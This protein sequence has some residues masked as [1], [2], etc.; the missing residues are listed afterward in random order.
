[1]KD[2]L[3]ITNLCKSYKKTD[4]SLKNVTITIPCG[5]I[6]GF[7]GKNGAGKSTTINALLGIG[8]KDSGTV[9]L[10]GHDLDDNN[11]D[12]RNEIGVVF[13]NTHF[14][15]ENTPIMIEKVMK[16]IYNNWDSNQFYAF[17]ERFSL[18]INKKVKTFSRGMMMKLSAAVALSHNA[19]F[20]IL[21]EATA[22]LDPV[23][24]EELLDILLEFVE[25]ENHSILMSSHISSD[26]ERVADYISF[27]HNGEIILTESK[28]TL[29]YDYGIARMKQDDFKN[30]NKSEYISS[31]KRGL[32]MEVLI[33][34]KK[35]FIRSYP[36]L[37]VDNTN[38]DELLALLTKEEQ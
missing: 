28:D 34:N 20:L 26:L 4:F 21:D 37:V 3:Q 16:D 27:I 36:N 31:R 9:K 30:L 33:R 14:S 18:P 12:I 7:V 17:L 11:I 32:Q 24:R 35:E 38:I 6:M 25:D 2:A 23:A 8:F 19:S 22:G 13:D 15:I 1:M 5:S 10:F 29:I